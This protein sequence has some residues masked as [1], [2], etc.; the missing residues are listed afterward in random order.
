MP[1]PF[2]FFASSL[3]R[4]SQLD[5]KL[6]CGV[7]LF[8]EESESKMRLHMPHRLESAADFLK[9]LAREYS[10]DNSSLMAAAVSY[11]AFVSLIPLLLAAAIAISYALGSPQQAFDTVMDWLSKAGPAI[12]DEIGPVIQPVVYGFVEQ[13]GI[14]ILIASVTLLWSGSSL[15]VNLGTVMNIAWDT[16]PRGFLMNYLVAFAMLFGVGALLLMSFAI[17]TLASALASH[18]IIIAGVDLSRLFRSGW[19]ALGFLLPVIITISAFTLMYKVMPNTKVRFKSAL[20]GGLAAGLLWEFAKICFS[21][22]V[23][24]IA[25]PSVIYGSLGGLILFLIWIYYSSTVVIISAQIAAID[26]RRHS[27]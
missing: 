6:Q 22:Y 20:F 8:G 25:K 15:F 2:I 7:N 1:G 4:F 5:S 3:N 16:K 9:Q 24:N 27:G 10:A 19:Q 23:T 13:R 17:T 12:A 11:Y 21:Y 18:Q 14:G 26:Q